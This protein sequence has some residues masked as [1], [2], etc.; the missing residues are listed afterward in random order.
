LQIIITFQLSNQN[1]S[2]WAFWKGTVEKEKNNFTQV[3]GQKNW[4]DQ[5][6]NFFFLEV[7]GQI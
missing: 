6:F 1:A 2:V 3:L 5:L 7:A 4:G